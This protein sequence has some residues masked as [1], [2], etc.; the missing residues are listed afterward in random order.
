MFHIAAIL[1]VIGLVLWI[2]VISY[3]Y[4]VPKR[5][6]RRDIGGGGRTLMYEEPWFKETSKRELDEWDVKLLNKV[7][8]YGNEISIEDLEAITGEPAPA[9]ANQIRRLEQKGFLV[10]VASGRYVLTEEG[11]R[12]V[13]LFKEK[14]WY[15]RKEKE[16]LEGK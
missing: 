4:F 12:Y 11:K 16:I 6:Q 8:K 2:G 7:H 15:R 9:L 13:E 10:K 1:I 14:L 5:P 3:I